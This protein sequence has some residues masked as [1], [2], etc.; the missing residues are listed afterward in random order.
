[1]DV[2]EELN[3]ENAKKSQ[4]GEVWGWLGEGVGWR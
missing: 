1:M 4:G 3:C 2:N